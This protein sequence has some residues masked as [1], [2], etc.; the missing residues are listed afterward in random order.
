MS[1]NTKHDYG[2]RE[3]CA[4]LFGFHNLPAFLE[5]NGSGSGKVVRVSFVALAAGHISI[6]LVQISCLDLPIL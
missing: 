2:S 1:R 6:H 4:D 5:M 3:V